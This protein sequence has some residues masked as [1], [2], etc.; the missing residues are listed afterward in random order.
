MRN[1]NRATRANNEL[2]ILYLV[3]AIAIVLLITG[4]LNYFDLL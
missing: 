2:A 3:W 4:L 1:P